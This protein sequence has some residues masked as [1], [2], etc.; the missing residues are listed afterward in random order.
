MG[1]ISPPPQPVRA[2]A[3]GH[4]W[5][6]KDGLAGYH[7]GPQ[8]PSACGTSL[9]FM[10]DMVGMAGIARWRNPPNGL[11]CPGMAVQVSLPTMTRHTP[12]KRKRGIQY[13]A[14]SRLIASASGILDRPV[15]PCDDGREFGARC[16]SCK[17]TSP[18]SRR[19]AP[20]L[21]KNFCPRKQR[22][23]GMPGARCT[24]SLVCEIKKHTSVVTTG[25]PETSGLPCAMVLT[26]SFVLSPVTG[27]FCHRRW[28]IL[29]R[30]LTPASGRQDHTTSPSALVSLVKR[31]L[32]VHRIPPQRS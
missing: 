4:V 30:N 3:D 18:S 9:I 17:H 13:A 31:H 15:K 11:R 12:R 6:S 22:A 14:A 20:E 8:W 21:C 32:R 16:A 10:Q 25:S 5:R 26:A 23:Q 1:E 7:I 19:D 29:P 24:R 2:G 28:R 27:L